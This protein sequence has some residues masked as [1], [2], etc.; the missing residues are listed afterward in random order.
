MISTFESLPVVTGQE[1]SAAN[2]TKTQDSSGSESNKKQFGDILSSQEPSSKTTKKGSS[3]ESSIGE[4]GKTQHPDGKELPDA[5]RETESLQDGS[6]PVNSLDG[7]KRSL[8]KSADEDDTLSSLPLD[9]ENI[10]VSALVKDSLVVPPLLDTKV[11]G[12][13]GRDSKI[14]LPSVLAGRQGDASVSFVKIDNVV[15][16]SRV[17]QP[18]LPNEAD[19]VA[20]LQQTLSGKDT[21]V[22]GSVDRLI[23]GALVKISAP[24]LSPVALNTPMS[25][26]VG[27]ELQSGLKVTSTNMVM[28]SSLGEPS[29]DSEFVGRV[30]MVVK[31]GMQE[32]RIQ[33]SPPEMGR[34][35]IKVTT[36]GDTAKVMFSVDNVAARDAI[37]QAIPRLRELLGQGGLQLSH[38]GV[39][40]YSEPQQ[41]RGDVPEEFVD[42]NSRLPDEENESVATW[43]LDIS[44]SSST[45]DYY[46]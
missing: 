35:E 24:Q 40:D 5:E 14:S 30:N 31:G 34:L 46:I 7:Y 36:E 3:T 16:E 39:S 28:T 42:G 22:T 13:E 41:G 11:I 6:T 1:N 23:D 21:S 15:P 44:S 17:L 4:S 32:A 37:E 8:N 12:G 9:G 43:Q 33:L 19:V 38:T 25:Q 29:W 10:A 20:G 45:V 26:G 2:L 27:S 18:G